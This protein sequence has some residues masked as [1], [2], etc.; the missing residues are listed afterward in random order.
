MAKNRLLPALLV[1]L[2]LGACGSGGGNESG[3][4]GS[5]TEATSPSSTPSG[6]TTSGPTDEHDDGTDDAPPFPA[7]TRPD[8]GDAS[9]GAYGNIT[10]VRVAHHD[11]FDRVVFEF[12]G[13]GTPG[14]IVEYVPQAFAQGS[15]EPIELAGTAVLSITITGVGYPTE[16]GIEEFRRG[17]VEPADAHVVTGAFFDGTFEGTTQAFVGTS[18]Q[19]PFRVYLLTDP[20][21]IVL[22]VREH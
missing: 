15:G 14:W 20:A 6:G 19:Q 3:G 1:A 5:R 12:H 2:L 18:A 7:D 8:T 10:D 11:D 16:T 22:E 21:R 13:T 9:T 4:D 17:P